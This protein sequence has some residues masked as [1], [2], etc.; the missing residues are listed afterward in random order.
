MQAHCWKDISDLD[1]KDIPAQSLQ[2]VAHFYTTRS[3]FEFYCGGSLSPHRSLLRRCHSAINFGD[4]GDYSPL[5]INKAFASSPLPERSLVCGATDGLGVNSNEFGA[6]R[7]YHPFLKTKAKKSD[8]M[9]AL[10]IQVA[11]LK[12]H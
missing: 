6:I 7:Q 12:S 1:T 11:E 10:L 3:N 8:G 4:A 5:R 9:D 2:S